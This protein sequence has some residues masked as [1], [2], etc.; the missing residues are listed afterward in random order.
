MKALLLVII[1]LNQ[2]SQSSPSWLLHTPSDLIGRKDRQIFL[3]RDIAE[4]KDY[5]EE[6]ADSIDKEIEGIILACYERAKKILTTNRGKM[7]EIART[8][9]EK[10]TLEGEDLEAVLKDVVPEK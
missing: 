2:L 7:D 6:T 10:E 1:L 5:S 8:L 9:I 4:M 3:G